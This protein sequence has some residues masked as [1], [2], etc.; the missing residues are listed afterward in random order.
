LG[1]IN[2]IGIFFLILVKGIEVSRPQIISPA[3]YSF[4][5]VIGF[6][7]GYDIHLSAFSQDNPL[8]WL[9]Y[10]DS[11]SCNIRDSHGGW[12][13]RIRRHFLGRYF[14]YVAFSL[15]SGRRGLSAATQT[16]Q[17]YR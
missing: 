5:W 17:G 6:Q 14:S 4:K 9:L 13:L 10:S 1:Y 16:Q 3:H 2:Y 11:P 7:G 12:L 15:L 8:H